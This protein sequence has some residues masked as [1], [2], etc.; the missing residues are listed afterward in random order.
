MLI[1]LVLLC[2][3]FASVIVPYLLLASALDM[4]LR[5]LPLAKLHTSFLSR[6]TKGIALFLA[7]YSAIFFPFTFCLHSAEQ[8]PLQHFQQLIGQNGQILFI[9]NHVFYTDWLYLWILVHQLLT[10]DDALL[11]ILLKASIRNVPI[12]GYFL[13]MIGLTK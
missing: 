4:L 5:R 11:C 3:C 7:E 2:F 12:V 13:E 1:R 6:L 9:S 8:Q 10:R